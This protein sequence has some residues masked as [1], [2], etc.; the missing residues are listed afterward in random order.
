MNGPRAFFLFVVLCLSIL[1]FIATFKNSTRRIVEYKAS[2]IAGVVTKVLGFNRG[3]PI[4]LINNKRLYIHNVPPEFSKYIQQGDS[5]VKFEGNDLIISY[6]KTGKCS[7]VIYWQYT[8]K[9][10][11]EQPAIVRRTSCK[12]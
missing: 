2:R 6:R 5:V 1:F 11:Y 4:V 10:G 12:Q 8:I 3:F 7:D 9:N